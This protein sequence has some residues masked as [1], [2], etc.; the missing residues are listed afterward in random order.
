M[1]TS[2][3]PSTSSASKPKKERGDVTTSS[4]WQREPSYK[5][6]TKPDSTHYAWMFDIDHAYDLAWNMGYESIE[7]CFA[8]FL[9]GKTVRM[10]RW[11]TSMPWDFGSKIKF[12]G[13]LLYERAKWNGF[14]WQGPAETAEPQDELVEL[15]KWVRSFYDKHYYFQRS[16]YLVYWDGM[17]IRRDGTKW[18]EIKDLSASQI[19]KPKYWKEH[20]R[21]IG[22]HWRHPSAVGQYTGHSRS[23][24][25]ETAV[26]GKTGK[27]RPRAGVR[28]GTGRAAGPR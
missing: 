14:E 25:S 9:R 4:Q 5:E 24:E 2:Y 3:F 6:R 11:Y 17:N 23:A 15:A 28:R 19:D 7:D 13:D 26:A 21:S 16:E 10:W 27:R 20:G 18:N 1:I 12:T 22:V 8:P